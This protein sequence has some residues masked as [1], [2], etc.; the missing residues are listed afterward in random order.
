V[1]DYEIGNEVNYA[2]DGLI[3]TGAQYARQFLIPCV[4][5]A[6]R[7][8]TE[9]GL[10]VNLMFGSLAPGAG[11]GGGQ[12]AVAFLTEAY[13]NGARGLT[14]SLGFHPYGGLNPSVE[15]NMVTLPQRIRAVMT[16]NG[17]G[18]D[19]MWA[20]EYG[21][22][23]GGPNSWSEQVQAEWINAAYDAWAAHTHSGPMIWYAGRD[24]GTSTTDREQHFGIQRHDGTA[25][26]AYAALRAKLTR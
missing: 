6:R 24:S 9:L 19:K 15:P 14:D 10:P 2:Q 13:A 23:T 21:L 3:P 17:D 16:A 11:V 4:S 18:T 26:P 8:A 22:P 12:E 7:A 1:V 5:G 20:T 25:K